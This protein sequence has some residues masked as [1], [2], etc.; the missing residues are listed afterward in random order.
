MSTIFWITFFILVYCYFGYPLIIWILSIIIEN[1]VQK[2]TT[3]RRVSVVLSVYNE[4]EVIADKIKNLLNQD[5]PSELIDFWIGSDGSIDNTNSIV[6]ELINERVHLIEQAARKGKMATLN[7]LVKQAQGEI[8]VFTDARQPFK[9]DAIR[10]LVNNFDDTEIGCVSGELIFEQEKGSTGKGIN[11]YWTYE[12]FLRKV[13]SHVHSM[14]G[15]TGA[16]YAIRKSLYTPIPD[17]VILDDVFIPL[18]IIKKGYRAIFDSS[19]VAYDKVA[20]SSKQEYRR[21]TRTLYGNYQ[22]FSVFPEMFVPIISPIALQLFSHKFLR[23]IAPLFMILLFV[24]NYRLILL[25]FY[26]IL[27]QLQLL[28]YLM[29]F[30]GF[31]LRGKKCGMLG[32]ISKACAIPYVF[33]LLNFSA[34]VGLWKFIFSKQEVTWKKVNEE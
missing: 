32:R 15:A 17:P 10:Q 5:Y 4:E 11:F 8:I 3:T 1:K 19:A 29:V 21:K 30:I 26:A 25:P 31:L 13:E 22:I 34:L 14:I 27:F 24:F 12:K 6:K 18:H 16:I 28:F 9:K 20:E 23:V 33:F 7:L 2:G